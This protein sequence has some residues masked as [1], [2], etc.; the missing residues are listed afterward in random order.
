MTDEGIDYVARSRQEKHEAVC[1]ERYG[2]LW[3]AISDLKKGITDVQIMLGESNTQHHSRFNAISSRMWGIMLG[4][5]GG[6]IVALGSIV[7]YLL[8]RK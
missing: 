5:L 4:S 8:T 3:A 6:T 7:F 1:T 2:N